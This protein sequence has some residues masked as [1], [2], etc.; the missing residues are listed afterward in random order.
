MGTS[1]IR[2]KRVFR[3]FPLFAFFPLCAVCSAVCVLLLRVLLL[4]ARAVWITVGG[5]NHGG[6]CVAC[7]GGAVHRARVVVLC[8]VGYVTVLCAE[9]ARVW[10]LY[11]EHVWSCCAV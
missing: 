7:S 11:A 3:N 4:F 8:G 6:R 10:V 9:H 1:T 5:V 2:I